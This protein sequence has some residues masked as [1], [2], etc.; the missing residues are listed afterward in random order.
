MISFCTEFNDWR[1]REE[2]STS[3]RFVQHR[4]VKFN[5]NKTVTTRK[6][7][8]H[9]SGVFNSKSMGKRSLKITGSCKINQCCPSF[10]R[11]VVTDN[12]VNVTYCKTHHGHQNDIKFFP[13][14]SSVQE[15]IADKIKN[16]VTPNA[17]IDQ[18]R[19]NF[20]NKI[21]KK[22]IITTKDVY[23]IST[24]FVLLHKYKLHDIDA[25]SADLQVKRF[26]NSSSNPI[27]FY[28]TQGTEYPPLDLDDF[29]LII[30]TETQKAVLH[31]FSNG[32]LCI[33]STHGTNQYNF[34]LT[35][36]VVIDEFGEGYP[37]AFCISTKI[38]EVH[39]KVFFSKIKEVMGCFTPNVFM[40]D[41]VPAFWN[42]W[43]NIMWPIPQHRLLCKW[44][45]DNNWRKNLKKISG[46]QNVKA[47]VYK[48]LRVLLEEPNETQFEEL[49][50]SFLSKLEE[51][52]ALHNF[53][54]YFERT[55][56]HRKKLWAACYRHQV[57][58]NTNMVLE[59]FHKTLK[60]VYLKGKKNQRLDVLL[61]HLLKSL[62][63]KNF[64]RL[65][66]LC[67]GGKVNHYVN[68]INSRH[69]AAAQINISGIH[70][71]SEITWSVTSETL[72]QNYLVN[73]HELCSCK[74]ICVACKVCIHLFS[75]TCYYYT[76]KNNMC[77]H[78][79]AVNIN[80]VDNE[81][82]I[83]R[84]DVCNPLITDEVC[85]KI[86]IT[87]Q[88]SSVSTESIGNKLYEF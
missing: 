28:K 65:I 14:P 1:Q 7:Y 57:M 53:K 77:K 86:P 80:M 39:M 27:V 8:C 83:P 38:D 73:K 15:T 52:P 61:W 24:K 82:V 62:R 41:D 43:I 67:N 40:S 35:T 50:N 66:K 59:A 3:T 2:I 17:I 25:L 26:A 63:D 58:L 49:L 22:N 10:I 6:Y 42:A 54:T 37:A 72:D 13:I 19:D 81:V 20:D 16:G 56:V 4:G 68:A 36:I 55:Y 79:H 45:I 44:H 88:L 48:T 23:N 31:K 76:I 9:R 34:N 12:N 47:Y 32:K 51:E 11:I 75:C 5:K 18:I 21:E 64:E 69:R 70:Q 84:T 46:S 87:Q 74:I 78:I 33:D 60:H 30:L 85:M 71:V 29:M